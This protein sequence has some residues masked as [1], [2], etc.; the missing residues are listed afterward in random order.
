MTLLSSLPDDFKP[1]KEMLLNDAEKVA[2]FSKVEDAYTAHLP[3][4]GKEKK[5]KDQNKPVNDVYQISFRGICHSCKRGHL[6]I[7]A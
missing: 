3:L 1:R 2:D 7:H 4:E 6:L 5:S